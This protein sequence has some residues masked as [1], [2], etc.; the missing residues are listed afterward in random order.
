[1]R[2]IDVKVFG[3]VKGIG[4][5][6]E[7]KKEADELGITGWVKNNEENSIIFHCEG[8]EEK[9]EELKNWLE[10]GHHT[11]K[12]DKIYFKNSKIKGFENFEELI[13]Y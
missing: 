6:Y 10:Q 9:I 4:F 3:D 5:D 8:D 11:A 12:I 2:A 7:T 13:N 1:M